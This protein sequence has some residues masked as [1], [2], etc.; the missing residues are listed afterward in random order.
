MR[1][2]ALGAAAAVVLT[3]TFGGASVHRP[4]LPQAGRIVS[5]LRFSPH[6]GEVFTARNGSLFALVFRETS[7]HQVDVVRW[8]SAGDVTRR[9]MTFPLSYYLSDMSAGPYGV[10]AGTAVFR[11]FTNAPD[12]L[13]RI[14]PKSLTV[15][16]RAYFRGRV[17]TVEQG[18]RMWATIGDG[19][20]VRLDPRT[21]RV[22]ASHRLVPVARTVPGRG[23]V[24]L[25]NP[26]DGLGSL[27][28]L[29]GNKHRLELVRLNPAS[30]AL[31]S[32]TRIPKRSNDVFHIL[33]DADHVY[34]LG[35]SIVR[36]DRRGRLIGR[37]TPAFQI[38][39]AAQTYGN[40]LV[41]VVGVPPELVVLDA[42]GRTLARTDL[43]NAGGP[44]VVSSDDAWVEGNAG[45]G[46]GLVHIRLIAAR[47][48]S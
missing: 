25:S 13:L 5:T 17:T 28:V 20:V 2:A 32:R 16:A 11:R 45:Q 34:L 10:Y 21:L 3:A 19:R 30:L 24:A 46:N 9:R 1:L 47:P 33:G 23:D 14:D 12:R 48:S 7:S 36:V 39:F 41:A 40:G 29:A 26:A 22:L 6:L 44:L 8:R 4:R 42:R 18:R 35:D 43:G 15:R 27:W 38:S 37:P 31:L